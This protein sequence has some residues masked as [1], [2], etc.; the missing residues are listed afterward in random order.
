MRIIIYSRKCLDPQN[1][2]GTTLHVKIFLKL[3]MQIKKTSFP[4]TSIGINDQ[5]MSVSYC[6]VVGSWRRC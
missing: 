4:T 5:L 3:V 6:K 2:S 1:A